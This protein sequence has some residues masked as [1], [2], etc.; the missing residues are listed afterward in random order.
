MNK[1]KLLKQIGKICLILSL[2]G[3]WMYLFLDFNVAFT[4]DKYILWCHGPS[5]VA[6]DE[7]FEI[8]VEA[9]D[10]YERLAGPYT[11]T[12]SFEI[13]SYNYSTLNSMTS[14]SSL[15]SQYTFTSNVV[16]SGIIPAYKV[17]GA[18][19][20]KKTFQ[21]NISTIGIHYI[22]VI[23][24]GSGYHYR[25]NPIIVK[26]SSD[27]D[28]R[29]YWGDIHGHTSYSDG[30]GLPSEAFEFARDVALL[31]Y[32]AI[33]DH[34]EHFLRMGDIDLFNIF[35]NYIS[36]INQYNN[37]EDFVTL[38][39]MEW[40]PKYVV[41]GQDVSFGHLNVYFKGDT[42]PF[43]ST[44]IQKTP[45]ELYS[46]I[47]E[48]CDDEFIAWTHHS[49]KSSFAS[50]FAYH[51]DEINRMIE[52]YSVHGSCETYGE[53]N[54]YEQADELKEDGYSVRDSF[55]MGRRY[56]IMSSSD[57]HDG[58]L[59]HPISH[60]DA[61]CF[62]QYPYTL[63]GYRINHPYPGGLTGLFSESLNRTAVFDALKSRS[64]YATT[65]VN[66]HYVEYT[67]NGVSV[68]DDN[69]TL[70]VS[71]ENETREIEIL[72]CVDGLTMSS[73][74][75]SHIKNI[76]VYKNS[77]L[78]NTSLNINKAIDRV[79]FY[80]SDP[81]RGTNY[82]DYIQ[83]SDGYYYIN[84]KS[85]LPIDPSE[86]NTGGADYYYVRITDTIGGAAWIG[87]IWVEVNI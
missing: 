36:T 21:M 17:S 77:E 23:E 68:G 62:N 76:E 57:T 85:Q 5:I 53:D 70:F 8:T 41:L 34:S 2:L 63:S 45:Y 11:G 19:N 39:A 71:D 61:R 12:I 80:D 4:N 18:D 28:K 79:V 74:E 15:P 46:H 9:W 84:E 42:M 20:G 55:K 38:V 52:I 59:G 30:S 83:K 78:W 49:L 65:W 1:K 16:L 10:N 24:Q 81:I 7:N 3:F 37:P 86:L 40:T 44:F 13:E 25:S 64:G 87:P 22:H 51:D 69:S 48:N 67:I 35:Q 27:I 60:T 29:L 32:A 14:I 72:A 75:T 73:N 26:N 82:T 6:A 33:T 58:R 31:D 47:R 54:L 66:R 43:F 56:G 50:D